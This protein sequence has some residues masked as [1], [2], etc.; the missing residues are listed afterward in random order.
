MYGARVVVVVVVV[1][2][3]FGGCHETRL[4]GPYELRTLQSSVL[5][6]LPTHVRNGEGEVK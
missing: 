1:V 3:G 6:A 2:V 5:T 4:C